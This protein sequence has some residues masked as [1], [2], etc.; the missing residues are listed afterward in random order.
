MRN[1]LRETVV[2]LLADRRASAAP[3]VGLMAFVLLGATGLAVDTARGYLIKSKLSSAIDAAALAGGRD[4]E[5]DGVE[6]RIRRYFD[7]NFPEGYLGAELERFDIEFGPERETV[8]IAA[9]VDLPTTFMRIFGRDSMQVGASNRARRHA[10]G[11]E[12]ALVMDNTG[13]MSW[14]EMSAMKEATR[15]LV[16]VLYGEDDTAPNLWIALVPYTATVNVGTEHASWV[17]GIG[18]RDWWTADWKGCVEARPSPYDEGDATPAIEAFEPHYYASTRPFYLAERQDDLDDGGDGRVG[19]ND[20]GPESWNPSGAGA[21]LAG[22]WRIDARRSAGNA[23]VGPNLGCGPAVTPLSANRSRVEAAIDEMNSWSRGGTMA[24]LGL[25]WGWRAISPK[26]RGLWSGTDPKLPL[27]YETRYMDK[28]I[29]ILTDGENQWYDWPGGL[30]GRPE[31]GAYPDADYNA[32]GRLADGRLGTTD[33]GVANV[34][35]DRRMTAAC[36]AIKAAGIEI[37]AVTFKVTDPDVKSLFRGCA[38]A[39]ANYWNSPSNSDLSAAF[40][41]IGSKLSNLRLEK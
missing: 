1:D 17:D 24:N 4:I 9:R 12:L 10:R 37:Y 5:G 41:E 33:N 7:A 15:E 22:D 30:P 3:L 25:V 35:L 32:Y 14:S 21:G 23:A 20:W 19:G 40:R 2:R 27:D 11:L 29:V 34:E 6:A 8:T 36:D 28:A 26:W 18:D 39:P 16:G 13:S 38:S 31:R